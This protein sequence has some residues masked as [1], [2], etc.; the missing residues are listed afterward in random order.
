MVDLCGAHSLR[1]LNDYIP[2]KAILKR[3]WIQPTKNFRTKEFTEGRSVVQTI[4][5]SEVLVNYKKTN[6]Q[7][8]NEKNGIAQL[9]RYNLGSLQQKVSNSFT[10]WDVQGSLISLGALMN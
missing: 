5:S 8:R 6:N 2:L 1:I 9:S 10:K 3:T 4:L 7:S